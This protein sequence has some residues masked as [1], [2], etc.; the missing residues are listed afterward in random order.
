[1]VVCCMLGR[2]IICYGG[3]LR[4]T[5]VYC[6]PHRTV[7]HPTAVYC[8]LGWCTVW[9]VGALYVRAVHCMLGRCTVW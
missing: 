8:M 9:Y 6:A 3:V 2:C 4:V 7:R 5:A 1:M